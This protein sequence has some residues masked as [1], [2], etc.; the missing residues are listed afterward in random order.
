MCRRVSG[1]C[2][3]TTPNFILA[4]DGNHVGRLHRLVDGAIVRRRAW[5]SPWETALE[6]L[7]RLLDANSAAITV[8]RKGGGGWGVSFGAADRSFHE[9]YFTHYGA[10]N[11]LAA[12]VLTAP[13]GSVLTERMAMRRTDYERSEFFSDWARPQGFQYIVHVR[14]ENRDDALTGVGFTRP[15]RT[16]DFEREDVDLL[17]RLA[18]HFRRSVQTYLR[19]A[20]AR[21]TELAMG[22]ALDRMQRGAI[23][24]DVSGRVIFANQA[25]PVAAGERR[26]AADRRRPARRRARGLDGDASVFGKGG[27][28]RRGDKADVAAASRRPIRI[29]AGDPAGRQVG[30][31]ARSQFEASGA[32]CSDRSGRRS[33]AGRGTAAAPLRP[34]RQGSRSGDSRGN[35]RGVGCHCSCTRRG[36]QHGPVALEASL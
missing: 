36:P 15:A 20:E 28:P 4:G 11:P 5:R 18:P 14:V 34:D 2:H 19:L 16:G 13:E 10:I 24:L 1:V 17:R 26:H 33:P 6:A 30:C 27:N 23:G 9:S 32:P 31:F 25:R 21:T 7:A 12:R 29:D 35:G 3:G 8:D 22:E